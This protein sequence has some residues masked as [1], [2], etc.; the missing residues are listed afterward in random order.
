MSRG[1]CLQ[2]ELYQIE[3]ET[4]EIFREMHT[5]RDREESFRE[6]NGSLI[7]SLPNLARFLDVV[8]LCSDGISDKVLM[9]S[10]LSMIV[11]LVSA[12]WQV[13]HLKSFFHHIKIL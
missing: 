10:V 6:L 8:A 4:D 11:M 2:S 1:S 13:F 12:A 5:A 3:L 7:D 9:Y